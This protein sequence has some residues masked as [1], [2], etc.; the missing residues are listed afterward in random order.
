MLSWPAA[1]LYQ[2]S[3]RSVGGSGFV[4]VII[5]G[6][7]LSSKIRIF[8]RYSYTKNSFSLSVAYWVDYSDEAGAAIPSQDF[9]LLVFPIHCLSHYAS[10]NSTIRLWL[11]KFIKL[12]I[13][14]M[15]I[16]Y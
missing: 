3:V 7:I 15:S 2:G 13:A 10:H 11:L 8:F 6:Y 5:V 4:D 16:V 14:Q 9:S 12:S 1:I